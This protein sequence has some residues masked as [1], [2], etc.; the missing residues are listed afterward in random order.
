[1]NSAK[2][3]VV[4]LLLLMVGIIPHCRGVSIGREDA[5]QLVERLVTET[6]TAYDRILSDKPYH[7]SLFAWGMHYLA[8]ACL[9][10]YEVTENLS[11]FNRALNITDYLVFYSDVNAD[12]VPSWGSYNE[13]FGLSK[14]EFKEYTVW[15]AVNCLPIIE[16]AELIRSDHRLSSDP[17]LVAQADAYL[18]LVRRVV[19][20]HHPFWTQIT[21]DQG[22]YWDDPTGDVG[23]YVNGFASLGTVELLLYGLTGN[24]TYLDRPRQMANYMIANMRYDEVDDLYTWDYLIGTAPAEDISHGAI[25]LEFLITANRMEILE[26]QHVLRLCNTY[27]KR[28]WNVPNLPEGGF[29]LAMRVDG[30][31][32]EDYTRLSRGWIQLADYVPEIY[33]RQRIALGIHQERYGLNAAGYEVE[34]AAQIILLNAKLEN[35]GIDPEAFE[36]VSMEHLRGILSDCNERLNETLSM[37]VKASGARELLNEA[38][39]CVETGQTP[40]AS[41][42]IALV[43]EAWDLLGSYLEAGHALEDL[44]DEMDSVVELG[45][46]VSR[47][48]EMVESLWERFREASSETEF[49]SIKVDLEEVELELSRAMAAALIARADEAVREAKEMGFDTSRH[50]IFLNRAHEEYDKG[51]YGPAA[52]FTEYP[53]RLLKELSEM[54]APEIALAVLLILAAAHRRW[55]T[56]LPGDDPRP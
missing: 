44:E 3:S 19:E 9:V 47:I 25:D 53:L 5:H 48:S 34:A 7:P 2:A 42:V 10:M 56:R 23:P 50:E 49:N 11:W 39:S 55:P 45:G 38:Y 15:D 6:E 43:W 21:E 13:T 29:P 20:R 8:R 52:Q 14:W 33:E 41:V 32:D 31:G 35:R 18:E 46:N 12:G 24:E 4:L 40:N 36:P 1:M 30:S 51:N 37:G 17:E 28:I 22:Y 26:D 27:R 16:S 54:S